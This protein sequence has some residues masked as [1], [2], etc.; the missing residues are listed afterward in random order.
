MAV[1]LQV[2]AQVLVL[3]VA[4]GLAALQVVL[5]I[6]SNSGIFPTTLT[7]IPIE[8]SFN[9]ITLGEITMLGFMNT[10]TDQPEWKTKVSYYH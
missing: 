9:A 7:N 6:I 3:P 4:Q 10:V 8:S 1:S 5:L 2:S